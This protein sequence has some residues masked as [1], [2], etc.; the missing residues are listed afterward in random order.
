MCH[1]KEQAKRDESNKRRREKTQEKKRVEDERKREEERKKETPSETNDSGMFDE[2]PTNESGMFD[3]E[4][5]RP[6]PHPSAQVISFI[7]RILFLSVTST[8][9]QSS[10]KKVPKFQI[11]LTPWAT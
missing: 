1:F 6:S 4:P 2:E 8:H 10:R 7:F 5:R 9:E 11:N 3:E